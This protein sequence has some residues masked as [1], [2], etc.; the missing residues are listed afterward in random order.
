MLALLIFVYTMFSRV[1][2]LEKQLEL[3]QDS[4]YSKVV[5]LAELIDPVDTL[6]GKLFG[7]ANKKYH[8]R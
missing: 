6:S 2:V 3:P 7:R 1:M 5:L 8:G 4:V